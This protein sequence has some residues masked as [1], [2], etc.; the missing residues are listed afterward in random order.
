MS[1]FALTEKNFSDDLK[2]F[3]MTKVSH[4]TNADRQSDTEEICEYLKRRHTARYKV[5]R[6]KKAAIHCRFFDKFEPTIEA[7]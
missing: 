3:V 1:V 4:Q 2:I 7:D 5:T 6:T